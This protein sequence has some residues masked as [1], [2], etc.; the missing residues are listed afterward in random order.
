MEWKTFLTCW[1]KH[2]LLRAVA[3]TNAYSLSKIC[4][5]LRVVL[6]LNTSLQMSLLFVEKV[7]GLVFPTIEYNLDRVLKI[8]GHLMRL[9]VV[10]RLLIESLLCLLVLAFQ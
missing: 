4:S 10:L 8:T 9:E 3:L 1:R 2:F 7:K 5:P 6:K